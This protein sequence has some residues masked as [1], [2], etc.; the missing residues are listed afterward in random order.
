[1]ENLLFPTL[2]GKWFT[3][4]DLNKYAKVVQEDAENNPFLDPDLF[5]EW[6]N[7][8]HKTLGVD[9]S[10]GGYMEDRE[11]ILEGTYLQSGHR[12]HLG[13]DYWVPENTPVHMPKDGELVFYKNDTDQEGGWGGKAIFKI[14]SVYFIFGHLRNDN[15]LI[16]GRK[17]NKGGLIGH[18]APIECS[19]GWYP[20]LHV[21]CMIQND[22]NVDG[23]GYHSSDMFEEFPCP[24]V[25]I[26]KETSHA[27]G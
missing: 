18:V 10:W 6:V 19:G 27:V 14:D 12:F 16:V 8:L 22:V 20:H 26:T 9:Y 4:I 15:S 7:L 3:N 17:L 1:M 25:Q 11:Q 24:V 21:Q 13:V 23:Y 5:G 2:K